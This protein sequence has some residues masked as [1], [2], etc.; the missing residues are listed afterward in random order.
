MNRALHS[1]SIA[2]LIAGC[3]DGQNDAKTPGE[4]LGTFAMTGTLARDDCEAAVLGVVDPWE[5][6]VRL[7]RFVD[8]F[9]WLNGREAISGELLPDERS[10]RLETA[11]DV[12]L[13]QPRRGRLGCTLTRRD[14]ASGK[15]LPSA[16]DA[17][18]VD[19]EISFMYETRSGSDCSEIIGISG[20]F[21][22]LPCRVDFYLAGERVGETE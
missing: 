7:S 3:G 12:E 9:Y 15:V 16:N 11:V 2:L 21:S 19:A 13:T 1:A 22:S 10:F 8:D 18:A 4:E 5:F 14:R 17:R 20:G 6:K